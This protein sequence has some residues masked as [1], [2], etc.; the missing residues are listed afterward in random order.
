VI[1]CRHPARTLNPRAP[2]GAIQ[3]GARRRITRF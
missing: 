1:G 2:A 3:A